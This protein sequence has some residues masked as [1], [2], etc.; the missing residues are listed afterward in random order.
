MGTEGYRE[1]TTLESIRIGRRGIPKR[2][3]G[4]PSTPVSDQD[5]QPSAIGCLNAGGDGPNLLT[6]SG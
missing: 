5:L 6:G 1:Q 4:E 3:H 2:S